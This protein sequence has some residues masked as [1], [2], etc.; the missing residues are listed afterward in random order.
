MY[1]SRTRDPAAGRS[2]A[3]AQLRA[4]TARPFDQ[5]LPLRKAFSLRAG[6]RKRQ[7]CTRRSL[8]HV[9]LAYGAAICRLAQA[10]VAALAQAAAATRAADALVAARRRH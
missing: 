1:R 6:E 5:S 2:L 10:Q 8:E 9:T 7:H 3:G 4:A